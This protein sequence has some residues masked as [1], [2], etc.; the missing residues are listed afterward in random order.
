MAVYNNRKKE[1]VREISF[2]RDVLSEVAQKMGYDYLA[3][4]YV[5]KSVISSLKEMAN[6]EITAIYVP[7]LGTMYHKLYHIRK[8]LDRMQRK[9]RF[10][11]KRY[12][13][14]LAKRDAVIEGWQYLRNN[15]RKYWER[16]YRHIEK[17]RLRTWRYAGGLSRTDLCQM[18][19]SGMSKAE[20]YSYLRKIGEKPV[21]M[22]GN[23]FCK[24]HRKDD[25]ADTR[26]TKKKKKKTNTKKK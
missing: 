20:Y 13:T 19:N 4:E 26:R 3:V 23:G 18:Q 25:I 10:Y 11:L 14:Y 5:Y 24:Y 21:F 7:K 9:E 2:D 22:I 6:S 8:V 15:K 12:L 1:G 17:T 16:R